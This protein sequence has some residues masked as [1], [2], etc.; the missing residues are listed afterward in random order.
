MTVY[1]TT[2]TPVQLVLDPIL[3]TWSFNVHLYILVDAG[4]PSVVAQGGAFFRWTDDEPWQPAPTPLYDE[5][6]VDPIVRGAT[7]RGYNIA[8]GQALGGCSPPSH[9]M[10]FR[11]WAAADAESTP[12]EVRASAPVVT[13]QFEHPAAQV[14]SVELFKQ[15]AFAVSGQDGVHVHLVINVWPPQA[16]AP[17][18]YQLFA[19][20]AVSGNG[21]LPAGVPSRFEHTYDEV[22]KRNSTITYSRYNLS[23]RLAPGMVGKSIC[24]Q[25]ETRPASLQ[26]RVSASSFNGATGTLD[27]PILGI[28][29]ISLTS[30]VLV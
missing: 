6:Q 21:W 8:W 30:S 4:S 19:D 25:D 1:N 17:P 7:R 10:Q 18:D 28:D 24:S 23:W 9:E 5:H 20:V 22:Q 14:L 26:I 2:Q 16:A 11:I 13:V 12:V 3:H 15:V 27:L 29:C